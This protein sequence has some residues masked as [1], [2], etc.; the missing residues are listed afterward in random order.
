MNPKKGWSRVHWTKERSSKD[1][2]FMVDHQ[3]LYSF[4]ES[5]RRPNHH[6]LITACDSLEEYKWMINNYHLLIGITME[7]GK[8]AVTKKAFM[9]IP[10]R[11]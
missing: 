11:W 8:R 4:N 3:D 2:G 5:S 6:V 7:R 10:R 1:L 9:V